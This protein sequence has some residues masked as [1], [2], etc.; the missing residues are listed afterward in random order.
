MHYI[1][2]YNISKGEVLCSAVGT[3]LS[4]EGRFPLWITFLLQLLKVR[5]PD[6]FLFSFILFVPPQHEA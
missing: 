3:I 1:S 5:I 6:G 4:S 2:K